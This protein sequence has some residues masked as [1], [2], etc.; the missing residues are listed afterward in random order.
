M[1]ATLAMIHPKM[2]LAADLSQ[3][4]CYRL[5]IPQPSQRPFM[6]NDTIL[7]EICVGNL[8]D[9]LAVTRLGAQRLEL[10]GALV[11]GGLTPSIG[12]VEQV[13]A[14]VEVPVMVMVRPRAGGFC[15]SP[16]ELDSMQRDAVRMLE[17]GADGIV[18]G[19]LTEQANDRLGS[20]A[21][22]RRSRGRTRDRVSPRVRL[23][24]RPAGRPRATG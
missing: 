6:P 15:Y 16:D 11:L 10:C 12:L 4:V 7:L 8:A 22:I 5:I 21:T 18:F 9:A 23:R 2:A 1:P 20:G 24:R 17:A 3:V 19:C 13:V 14:A